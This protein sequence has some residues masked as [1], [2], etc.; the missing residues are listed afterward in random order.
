MDGC[1]ADLDIANRFGDHFS[2]VSDVNISSMYQLERD[3]GDVYDSKDRLFDVDNITRVIP[4]SPKRVRA[5]G[6][7]ITAEHI[8]YAD[9]IVL[10]HLSKLFSAITHHGYCSS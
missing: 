4:N 9:P 2:T 6:D 1:T 10:N 3:I 8:F 7:N 5:A